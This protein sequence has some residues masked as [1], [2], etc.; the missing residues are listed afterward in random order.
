MRTWQN[1]TMEVV[2]IMD[3]A[4][5]SPTTPPGDLTSTGGP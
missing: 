3:S 1:P 5:N 4:K 2:A